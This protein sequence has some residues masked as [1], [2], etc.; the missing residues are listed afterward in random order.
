MLKQGRN[1]PTQDLRS[2]PM[3]R[4]LVAAAVAATIAGC[5]S[6]LVAPEGPASN[7][8]LD[9]VDRA[10]GNLNVGASSIRYLLDQ[11]GNDL[12]FLDETAKLSDGRVSP[13]DYRQTINS[14][15]PA[16]NNKAA[17]DCVLSQLSQ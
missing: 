15:Y 4:F 13:D 14:F 7:A 6:D 11:D 9:Q 1:K 16:G 12:T 2:M 5:G 8:F 17:I 3:A 10:C